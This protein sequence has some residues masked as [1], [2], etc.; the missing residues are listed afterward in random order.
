MKKVLIQHVKK[1]PEDE[2][3]IR[4]WHR[5]DYSFSFCPNLKRKVVIKKPTPNLM[6]L[7]LRL[8]RK[9]NI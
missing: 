4:G 2:V 1:R 9:A 6:L 5:A 8:C 3:E 7:S